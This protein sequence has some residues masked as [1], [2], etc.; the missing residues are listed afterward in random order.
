VLPDYLKALLSVVP[1]SKASEQQLQQLAKLAAL[2][3]RAKD[4]VF[5]PTIGEVQEYVPSQLYI[6]QPPQ[7]WLN[8]V[9]QHMQQVSPLSPHQARAQFLGLVSA[10][11]MFGSSFF[12]IQS[13]SNISILA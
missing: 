2:Q 3:H 7:P 9:T 8:M 12:Y 11:P 6:R 13:S 4:T 1:Q 5:L 10:F